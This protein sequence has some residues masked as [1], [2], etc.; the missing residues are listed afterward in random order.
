MKNTI[1]FVLSVGVLTLLPTAQAFAVSPATS[2][3]R[4]NLSNAPRANDKR[5]WAD[6]DNSS[7]TPKAKAKKEEKLTREAKELLD[8]L[9]EKKNDVTSHLVVAQIAPATR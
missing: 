4:R 1:I 8:I 9:E 5:L 3:T 7:E 2:F 6:S